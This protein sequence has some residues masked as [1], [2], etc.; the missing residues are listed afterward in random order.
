[1]KLTKFTK[2]LL[3][4]LEIVVVIGALWVILVVVEKC[5]GKTG[6]I[7]NVI[8][9]N[10]AYESSEQNKSFNDNMFMN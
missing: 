2:F 4:I 1:M 7:P 8:E 5:R 6:F 10:Y 9:N 3:I